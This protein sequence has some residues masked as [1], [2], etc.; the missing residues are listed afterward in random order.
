MRICDLFS[1]IPDKTFFGNDYYLYVESMIDGFHM[2][3]VF[4]PALRFVGWWICCI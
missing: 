4:S 2:K 3:E 1:P